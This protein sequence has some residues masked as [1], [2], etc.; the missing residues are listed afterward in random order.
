VFSI[1]IQ[2][3]GGILVGGGFT[4][5]A[6]GINYVGRLNADGSADAAFQPATAD[7][8]NG[9]ALQADGK[10]LVGGYFTQLAGAARTYIG[11]LNNTDVATQS[12]AFDGSN[13]TWV[14]GGTSPDFSRATFE[15]STNGVDSFSVGTPVRIS[16]GWQVT[17]LTLPTN[18]TIR[19]RG[20][21]A[22]AVDG[23]P[24]L[25][26]ETNIGQPL[27]TSGPNDVT[28]S[29]LGSASF[30]VS[31]VGAAPLS[32]QW[33]KNGVPLTDGAKVAGAQT[34]NLI[35]S[36]L[37]GADA[38]TLSVVVNNASGSITSRTAQLTVI[39]PVIYP[40]PA[41][42]SANVGQ[43]VTLQ[44][45]VAGTQP[46]HYQWRKDSQVMPGRTSSV[47]ALTNV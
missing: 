18:S 6:G 28:V 41:D 25:F 22:G 44:V 39:D 46:I 15:A 5:L 43:T 29:T 23:S 9:I 20:F 24:A 4:N 32:F 36:S 34:A 13:L 35:L 2:A 30:G 42:A 1:V 8:V 40:F 16:G 45:G 3:D 10:V 12:L 37:Y 14:C 26:L 38:G 31:V 7:W 19:A 21:I 17:G 33:L 27:V 11:R 47:L